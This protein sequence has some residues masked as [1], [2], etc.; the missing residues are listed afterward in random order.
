MK[1]APKALLISLSL[2][3]RARVRETVITPGGFHVGGATP[4]VMTVGVGG[5]ER[6]HLKAVHPY[7]TA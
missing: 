3:E 6:L 4:G 2:R 7:T 5:S 1:V